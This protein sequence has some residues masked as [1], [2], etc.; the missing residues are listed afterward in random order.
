VRRWALTAC[1]ATS[2]LVFAVS[3]SRSA[4]VL[5]AWAEPIGTDGPREFYFSKQ[6][7]WLDV[8]WKTEGGSLIEMAR[9]Q[10]QG[11]YRLHAIVAERALGREEMQVEGS[12]KEALA[13]VEVTVVIGEY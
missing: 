6:D 13:K 2:S 8:P 10:G 5:S 11:T 9:V 1:P 12:G 3:G 4:V 7:G